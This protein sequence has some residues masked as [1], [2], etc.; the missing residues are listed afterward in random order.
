VQRQGDPACFDTDTVTVTIETGDPAGSL[1]DAL[2][3]S[4]TMGGPDPVLDWS[5][6]PLTPD[7][8]SVHRS[9]DPMDL[10]LPGVLPATEEAS[11][12][13]QGETFG[14]P[15]SAEP[16]PSG[17]GIDVLFYRVFGLNSCTGEYVSP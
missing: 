1:A 6:G 4:L 10:V 5:G 11:L 15:W 7:R 17:T 8:Y 13:A 16:P 2:R 3:V 14:G 9:S 12:D